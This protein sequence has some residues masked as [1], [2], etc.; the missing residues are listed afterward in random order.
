MKSKGETGHNAMETLPEWQYIQTVG[1]MLA[2]CLPEVMGR[3]MDTGK[4]I[5]D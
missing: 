5:T 3:L 2:I 1:K 4:Q